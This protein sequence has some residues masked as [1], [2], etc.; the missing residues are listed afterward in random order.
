MMHKTWPNVGPKVPGSATQSAP[1]HIATAAQWLGPWE[2][3]YDRFIFPCNCEPQ[4]DVCL[5]DP[6]LYR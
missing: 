5:E 6:V 3:H 4:C 1:I 2:Y